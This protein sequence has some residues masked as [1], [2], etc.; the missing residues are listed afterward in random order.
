[1][2]ESLLEEVEGENET[3][4][5]VSVG[6]EV[7]VENVNVQVAEHEQSGDHTIWQKVK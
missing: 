2:E 7:I 6:A 5:R 1:M 3:G 4:G